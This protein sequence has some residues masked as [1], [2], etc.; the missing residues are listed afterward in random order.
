MT[1]GVILHVEAQLLVVLSARG[2]VQRV[3]RRWACFHIPGLFDSELACQARL[4]TPEGEEEGGV[5]LPVQVQAARTQLFK[6]LRSWILTYEKAAYQVNKVALPYIHRKFA[7]PDKWTQL[8][9]SD[10][11]AATRAALGTEA[12]KHPQEAIASATFRALMDHPHVFLLD[13]T[14]TDVFNVAPV[15]VVVNIQTVDEWTKLHPWKINGFA[16]RLKAMKAMLREEGKRTPRSH[17]ISRRPLDA[18]FTPDDIVILNFLRNSLSRTR[19][20]QRDPYQHSLI[21]ISRAAGLSLRSTNEFVPQVFL[22]LGLVAP[23]E[24]IQRL[25][26]IL[27]QSLE[28]FDKVEKTGSS[29]T[30]NWSESNLTYGDGMDA[31]RHDW[32]DLEAYI[33]DDTT[34]KELDDAVSIEPLHDGSGDHWV[35]VHIA[36]PT[37]LLRPSDPAAVQARILGSSYYAEAESRNMLP[38][39]Y[40]QHFSLKEGK[41]QPVMT[42]SARITPDGRMADLAVRP[43]ILRNSRSIDYDTVDEIL[44]YDAEP[45]FSPDILPHID[46]GHAASQNIDEKTTSQLHALLNVGRLLNQRRI[47]GGMFAVDQGIRAQAA[48]TNAMPTIREF[49]PSSP[50]L[51]TGRPD[52]IFARVDTK[53][54]YDGSSRMMVAEHAVLASVVAGEYAKRTGT[55]FL[56]RTASVPGLR[57]LLSRTADPITGVIP[58]T[59]E[60]HSLRAIKRTTLRPGPNDWLGTGD[61]PTARVTS[62]LRR[63]VDV[64]N[65]WQLKGTWSASAPTMPL[66]ELEVIGREA[67][68]HETKYRKLQK[69]HDNMLWMYTVSGAFRRNPKRFENLRAMCLRQMRRD[70]TLHGYLAAIYVPDLGGQGFLFS[71]DGKQ[72]SELGVGGWTNVNLSRVLKGSPD[73][74]L[75]T[76]AR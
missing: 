76:F 28:E 62:P 6:A 18:K 35:H 42:F 26:P 64:V 55:P 59:E 66:S 56:Y 19:F 74:L 50:N 73:H 72:L 53:M 57:E 11:I 61:S 40:T 24:N 15:D 52:I 45:S 25:N 68:V 75:F 27:E 8:A 63:F 12:S 36:D 14:A 60:V 51:I 39:L 54:V 71:E 41:A 2:K 4:E 46:L 20:Y 16:S 9:V 70:P 7:N 43:G 5:D 48:I 23:W 10:A 33:I 17:T 31:V 37:A 32:G 67:D 65:H 29:P 34:A 30:P 47:A 38:S 1:E 58:L 49:P 3:H 21:T 22:D 44:R 69:A 13:G